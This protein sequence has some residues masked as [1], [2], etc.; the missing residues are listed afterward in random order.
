[1]NLRVF[2]AKIRPSPSRPATS[3]AAGLHPLTAEQETRAQVEMA[4]SD[5]LAFDWPGTVAACV[6]LTK[7]GW[8][9]RA[10]FIGDWDRWIVEARQKA[11]PPD[12]WGTLRKDGQVRPVPARQ[13]ALDR[14]RPEQ[15]PT[16]QGK[17]SEAARTP[18][19][20][21]MDSAT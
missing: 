16:P 19:S 1:M 6:E 8:T 15:V 21:V 13:A 17:L 10:K 3:P 9:A 18:A 5:E 11:W 2:P 20:A 7:Q 12:W 14:L 4:A